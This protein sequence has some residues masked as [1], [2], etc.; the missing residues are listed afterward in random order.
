MK[1]NTNVQLVLVHGPP[2]PTTGS[3]N[4]EHSVRRKQ[5]TAGLANCRKFAC[6]GGQAVQDGAALVQR[7]ILKGKQADKKRDGDDV[8]FVFREVPAWRS[9]RSCAGL[10][11]G[12]FPRL[13][14]S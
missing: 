3:D 13:P 1:C 8:F 12:G 9:R 10:L 14:A 5:G 6:R 7:Q 11:G 2:P 4:D